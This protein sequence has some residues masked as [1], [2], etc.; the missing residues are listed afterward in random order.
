[1][2]LYDLP[3]ILQVASL[4]RGDDYYKEISWVLGILVAGLKTTQV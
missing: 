1:M 3:Y 2:D 4:E